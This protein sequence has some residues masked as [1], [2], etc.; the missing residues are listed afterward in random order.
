MNL[1]NKLKRG[2]WYIA[3]FEKLEVE[4]HLENQRLIAIL[5]NG[6]FKEED[7][8]YSFKD[9][10]FNSKYKIINDNLFQRIGRVITGEVKF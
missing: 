1:L 9:A 8:N 2:F 5:T 7:F 4:L 6:V 10:A 3:G